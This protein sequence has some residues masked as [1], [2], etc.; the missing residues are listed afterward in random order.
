MRLEGHRYAVSPH[1]LSLA[2]ESRLHAARSHAKLRRALIGLL[3]LI[4]LWFASGLLVGRLLTARM[5]PHA[6]EPAPSSAYESLRLHTDDGLAIGAWLRV[7]ED[8]RA[9]VILVHGN[10]ASRSSMIDD[11]E[12]WFALGCTVMPISVRA[13]GDS[14]G[15]RN[16]AGWSARRDVEAA[17]A[18]LRDGAPERRIILH[19]MSLGSAA[20]LFAAAEDPDVA[21]L[22]LIGPYGDLRDAIRA[23]TRRALP[24]GAEALAFFAL[25]AASPIVLPELD[26]IRPLDAAERVRDDMPMVIVAGEL[27]QRAPAEVA[28]AMARDHEA[29]EV[30]IAPH[31]DHERLGRW[32]HSAGARTALR[33]LLD[34]IA[35][36]P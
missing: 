4:A 15:E 23:R 10:G 29:A 26:Q 7:H 33:H 16:D 13:H 30:I 18:H 3:V 19:G 11:A 24:W 2:L 8:E 5:R 28:Q 36:S 1:E 9:A 21:G 35:E 22:V 32:I 27:D 25:L 34:T 12:V 17:I 6:S 31:L 14:E 20:S